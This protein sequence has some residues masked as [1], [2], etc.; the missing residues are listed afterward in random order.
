VSATTLTAIAGGL[1]AALMVGAH[2]P[3]EGTQNRRPAPAPPILSPAERDAFAKLGS[4]SGGRFIWS[5]NRSGNHE[6]YA[7]ELGDQTIRQLTTHPNADYFGRVSPDGRSIAFMRGRK[8]GVSFREGSAAW[9]LHVMAADGTRERRLAERAVHPHWLPDGSGITFLRDNQV[10]VVDP[11]TDRARVLYEGAGAPTKGR[12]GDPVVG[13]DPLLCVA[14]RASPARG[15][16][17]VNLKTREY[18]R[19]GGRSA[20]QCTWV[21]G[22]T[23]AIWV[24]T[25]GHGGTRLMHAEAVKGERS[26]LM[27]V[28]GAYSHEYFPRVSSDGRWLVWGAAAAGHEHDKADYEMFA[29][30]LGADWSTVIRLT[31]SK[32][33]DQWPELYIPRS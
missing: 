17:I 29:W 25:Q 9:D 11:A 12:I 5:S 7:V 1:T 18:R 22:T 15:V 26:V 32:A 28:P 33:N 2:L 20:C 23:R 14:L 21:P 31:F 4:Q 10:F 19:L 27:D 13:P 16:G 8:P 3:L 24:E 30:R 6:L